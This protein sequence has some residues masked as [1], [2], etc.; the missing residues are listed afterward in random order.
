MRFCTQCHN[1]YYIRL[2]NEDGQALIYYCRNCGH[3]ENIS[4]T[5]IENL[6]IS[7]T[8][9]TSNKNPYQHIVNK[10]TKMDPTLPRI[11]NMKCPNA[12]CKSNKK[13]P[14]SKADA[15]E[16]STQPEIIYMRYDDKNM[17][18]IYLCAH[19]DTTWLSSDNK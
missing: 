7:K 16:V 5:N 4:E 1:M 2:S 12:D 3:S 8:N 15:D 19:C 17:K 18:F 6:C 9:I 13:A 14:E 10:F 11:K